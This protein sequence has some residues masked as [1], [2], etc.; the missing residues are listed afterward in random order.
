MLEIHVCNKQ[1]EVLRAFA[2]G[3]SEEVIIGR[4]ETVRRGIRATTASGA[5]DSLP[6][7]WSPFASIPPPGP[8]CGARPGRRRVETA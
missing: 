6:P 3:D 8:R 5:G 7:S 1:G 2:L 4:D